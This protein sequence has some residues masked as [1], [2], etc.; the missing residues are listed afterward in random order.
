M[1]AGSL[2]LVLTAATAAGWV[3]AVVGGGGL[4]LLPAMLLANPALPVATILGTNKLAAASGTSVAAVTYLR[5]TKVDW[6]GLGPALA[7]AVLCAGVGARLARPLPAPHH[8]PPRPC[9]LPLVP[10]G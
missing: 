5:R 8:P 7:A 6:R 1:P 2:A 9:V 3:D 4:L 10:G